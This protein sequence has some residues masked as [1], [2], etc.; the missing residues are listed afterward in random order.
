M[1]FSFPVTCVFF[2]GGVQYVQI[3][4]YIVIEI[5][6]VFVSMYVCIYLVFTY[7]STGSLYGNLG[8]CAV[9]VVLWAWQVVYMCLFIFWY[10][11]QD[12]NVSS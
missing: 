7:V 5:M 4:G 10:L 2:Y 1:S 6:F 8:L 3:C 11:K 9:E 12:N